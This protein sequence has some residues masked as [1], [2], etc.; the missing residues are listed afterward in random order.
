MPRDYKHHSARTRKRNP[1]S[2]WIGLLAGLLI[3]LFI[4]FLIYIKMLAPKHPELAGETQENIDTNIE[5]TQGEAEQPASEKAAPPKPRFEFYAILPEMEVIVPE[6]EIQAS[7]AKPPPVV[8]KST[9]REVPAAPRET[10]YLQ[11]GSFRGAAQADRLKARLAIMGFETDIQTITIN[12]KDTYHRV[13]V[14]P[15]HDLATLQQARS[16]LGKQGI[17]TRT[18]KIKG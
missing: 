11:A 2:P 3:G 16:K 9:S 8:E 14:G 7:A 18:V 1:V 15:F 5:A 13:R 10:Y 17:E 6:D 4:A 12:N